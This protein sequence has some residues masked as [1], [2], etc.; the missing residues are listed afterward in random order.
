MIQR[1]P[2]PFFLLAGVLKMLLG[3]DEVRN[4]EGWFLVAVDHPELGRL[5][6]RYSDESSVNAPDYYGITDNARLASW[7]LPEWK[8]SD[9]YAED[10]SDLSSSTARYFMRE[11]FNSE[12]FGSDYLESFDWDT[13]RLHVEL[14]GEL[15]VLQRR[16]GQC[17][18]DF[19]TWVKSATWFDTPVSAESTIQRLKNRAIHRIFG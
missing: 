4:S 7:V 18:E 9:V 19:V 16:S 3:D 10:Y 2:L 15:A 1:H 5:Y 12:R 11:L 14:S 17:E 6:W 13:E 8:T